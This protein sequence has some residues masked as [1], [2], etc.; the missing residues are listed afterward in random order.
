MNK[1]N[2][3][4]INDLYDDYFIKKRKNKY[5]HIQAPREEL[6]QEQYRILNIIKEYNLPIHEK[7]FGFVEGLS[8][9]DNARNHT[10]QDFVLNLDLKDFFDTFT[11]KE[12]YMFLK[13]RKVKNSLYISKVV[14][15]NGNMVQGAPTSPYLTNLLFYKHDKYLNNL[16]VKK[17][18][19]FSR[20]AD[21]ITFSGKKEDV[22]SIKKEI[23]DYLIGQG[24][25]ISWE[26]VEETCANKRQKVTGIVVNEHP[27]I[28]RDKANHIRA[29][30][31]NILRDAQ[32]KT[33]KTEDD[34][35]NLYNISLAELYGYVNF[36]CE[37]NSKFRKYKDQLNNAKLLLKKAGDN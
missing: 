13:N 22:L 2:T 29:I 21:D 16:A 23:F 33:I 4:L 11:Q 26:K 35:L 30:C 19:N 37:V 1:I 17:N 15:R 8:I 25:K 14:T 12:I 5:R 36:M 9:L 31:H 6:K 18:V 27:N 34:I 20:Y 32:N 3:K 28:I 24:F 10:N 7:A